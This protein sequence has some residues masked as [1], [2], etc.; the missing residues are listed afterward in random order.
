MPI[1]NS[2]NYLYEYVPHLTPGPLT[3]E[4]VQAWYA[5]RAIEIEQRTGS[6]EYALALLQETVFFLFS[7]TVRGP[8]KKPQ[9]KKHFSKKMKWAFVS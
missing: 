9:I 7:T 1:S 8:I 6:I 2:V 5:Q 3:I 4:N